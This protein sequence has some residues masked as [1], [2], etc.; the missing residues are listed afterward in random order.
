MALF[1][2]YG[3]KNVAQKS[4]SFFVHLGFLLVR[5]YEQT[6]T[7]AVLLYNSIS[8]SAL[9]ETK[10]RRGRFRYFKKKYCVFQR[11]LSLSVCLQTALLCSSFNS[12]SL[13][14]FQTFIYTFLCSLSVS[15]TVF[16]PLRTGSFFFFPAL[17]AHTR[18]HAGAHP[19]SVLSV[20][21]IIKTLSRLF[22]FLFLFSNPFEIHVN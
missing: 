19:V 21:F 4:M 11:V 7:S 9:K 20:R 1:R 14:C 12:E 2:S 10:Q 22:S 18:V 6:P 13:R 17:F 8:L 15:L 5:H 16:L 3:R